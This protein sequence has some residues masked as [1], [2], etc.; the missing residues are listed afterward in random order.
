MNSSSFSLSGSD[1]GRA[2]LFLLDMSMSVDILCGR[3][4]WVLVETMLEFAV[5]KVGF[6]RVQNKSCATLGWYEG[7]YLRVPDVW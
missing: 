3:C 4:S 6:R 7:V 2:R 1:S 5:D